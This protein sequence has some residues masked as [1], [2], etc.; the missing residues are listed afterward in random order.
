MFQMCPLTQKLI[1]NCS[2]FP[3]DKRKEKH[4]LVHI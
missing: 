2:H 4:P 1:K 3:G